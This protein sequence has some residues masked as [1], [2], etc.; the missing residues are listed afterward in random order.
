MAKATNTFEYRE[1]RS[2]GLKAFKEFGPH[3]AD[4]MVIF[5]CTL[6]P[7]GLYPLA[8][9]KSVNECITNSLS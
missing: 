1:G 6:D 9:A 3:V 8:F 7:R 2:D 4:E 5:L